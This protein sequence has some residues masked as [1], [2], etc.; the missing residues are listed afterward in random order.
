MM[1]TRGEFS[2]NQWTVKGPDRNKCKDCVAQSK[3]A[4]YNTNNEDASSGDWADSLNSELKNLTLMV[5]GSTFPSLTEDLLQMHDAKV[6]KKLNKSSSRGGGGDVTN[7]LVRRQFNCPDCPRYGRGSQVFFK[8]VPAL[9]PIC[10]CPRCKRASRGKCRRLYPVP[11]EE[12]KGYGLYKCTRCGDKWGSSRAVANIGQEC[13]SCAKKDETVLVIPFRLEKHR[14]KKGSGAGARGMRRIP[15][16][17]IREDEPDERAYGDTDRV[18][19]DFGGVTDGDTSGKQSFKLEPRERNSVASNF[20]SSVSSVSSA[21]L[22]F[23]PVG[24][25][26]RI[27]SGYKHKCAGCATGKCKNRRIPFSQVHDISDGNTV[28]TSASLMTNSS[29]DKTDFIDRDEDF[30]GFEEKSDRDWVQV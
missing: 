28:S 22:G 12:E 9:K 8:K 23:T 3:A 11:K 1:K 24:V 15:K 29:I 30:R 10:K 25:T 26:S 4:T 5:D 6:N 7:D 21:S 14:R 18:R 13:F 19:N 16:E 27:P 17:P 20:D 2:K